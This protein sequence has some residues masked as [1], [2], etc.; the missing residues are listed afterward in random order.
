L[1]R[2]GVA[3][4]RY[5]VNSTL[6]KIIIVED[7]SDS[8]SVNLL[9]EVITYFGIP[10]SQIL[11]T[12]KMPAPAKTTSSSSRIKKSS[13]GNSRELSTLYNSTH[14]WTPRHSDF[15][16]SQTV[17]DITN[18]KYVY[19]L[20]SSSCII[21]KSCSSRDEANCLSS[22]Y[23]IFPRDFINGHFSLF[24]DVVDEKYYKSF[25]LNDGIP[26]IY[27]VGYSRS[28]VFIDSKN[29]V[30]FYDLLERACS[31]YVKNNKEEYVRL[32]KFQKSIEG[33]QLSVVNQ[34]SEYFPNN[35]ELSILRDGMRAFLTGNYQTVF[36]EMERRLP[37]A[38]SHVKFDISKITAKSKMNVIDKIYKNYPMIDP[39]RTTA[40]I[41]DYIRVVDGK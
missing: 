31:D 16:V 29:W 40:N 32:K 8:K 37:F 22:G 2:G 20:T 28:K 33:L 36:R 35:S 12:S 39:K 34:L 38:S 27:N 41:E 14:R 25:N 3:R 7:S 23:I 11:Y 1:P 19:V 4:C 21:P 5:H 9:N 26:H 30:N 13:T 6:E 10:E 24:K 17:S 18:G 15:W